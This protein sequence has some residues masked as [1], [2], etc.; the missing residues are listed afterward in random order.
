MCA[1]DPKTTT[2]NGK[3][4]GRFWFTIGGKIEDGE[5]IEKAALRELYE[6]TGLKGEEVILGPIVWFGEFDLILSGVATRLK[7]AFIVARTAKNNFTLE[8]LTREEQAVVKRL[9]WFSLQ[10]I[11]NSTEVIYP[12][13]L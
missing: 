1:D 2:V 11:Q 9:D 8:N 7:Q 6:E 10:K 13:L 5:S 4:N 3:Y 12:V